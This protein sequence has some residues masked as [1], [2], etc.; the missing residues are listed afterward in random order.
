MCTFHK[1]LSLHLHT[2]V[3]CAHSFLTSLQREQRFHSAMTGKVQYKDAALPR[4]EQNTNEAIISFAVT[5]PTRENI[6]KPLGVTYLHA[7]GKCT[8]VLHETHMHQISML[9]WNTLIE[10]S[11]IRTAEVK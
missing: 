7:I 9:C 2:L 5:V 3:V 10:I 6:L 8:F 1:Q 4:F 11:M